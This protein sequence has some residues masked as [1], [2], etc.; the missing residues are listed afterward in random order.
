MRCPK[1]TSE[2][3]E[4][5]AYCGCGW[6]RPKK[7]IERRSE[8]PRVD[9]AMCAEPARHKVRVGAHL[10]MNVCQRHYAHA[11]EKHLDYIGTAKVHD[12]PKITRKQLRHLDIG[13]LRE[14]G[15]DREEA[16]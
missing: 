4:N 5:A 2:L 15:E 12:I 14:P 16:A 1:C 7:E 9:C 3:S 8:A 13:Q 6:K 10:W 11:G